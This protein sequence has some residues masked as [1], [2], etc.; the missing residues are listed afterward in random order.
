MEHLGRGLNE[1]EDFWKGDFGDGYVER[2]S[3]F[4]PDLEERAWGDMLR[5]APDARSFLECGSNIGRNLLTIRR[6]R[7]Q[8]DLSLIELN[9]KA[10]E[11]ASRA[12]RPNHAYN[13]PIAQSDLPAES[14]DLTFTS[15]VLIHIAPEQL[16][17]C[18]DKLFRYSRRYVLINEY[19]SHDPV[20]LEYRGSRNK[21]FKRDFGRYFL[22]RYP[23]RWVDYGF[24]WGVEY[25]DGG[26]D[27]MNW[28]LFEKK[29]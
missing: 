2:N 28:W 27:D 11:I 12:I 29:V 7:P 6:L 14:F 17:A 8:A 3:A 10:Y 15:G 1:Q 21:L 20:E 24:L 5:R 26:F 4:R 19:Y 13:G 9:R 22:E 25:Y 16:D 23:V 18:L